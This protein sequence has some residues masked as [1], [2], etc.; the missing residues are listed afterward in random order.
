MS[1][2][3][4]LRSFD[5]YTKPL[6]DFRVRTISG[7]TVT[8]ISAVLI[9]FLF[10]TETINF[11]SVDVVE[12]LYVDST[13]SEQ[14]VDV[15]FDVTF[16]K[17][18]CAF[19]TVDVMDVSGDNQDDIQDEIYKLRIDAYGKNI[20]GDSA[21]KLAVNINASVNEIATTTVECGSCYGAIEGCCNTCNEVKQAYSLRGWTLDVENVEQCRSDSWVQKLNEYKNE[22]CRVY[23]KV[24]VAKVAGNFHIAPGD[25]FRT[26]RSHAHDLHSLNP[27]KFDTSHVINH[28]SFGTPFPGKKYPLNGKH[29]AANKGGIMYQYYLKVVP[30]LYVYLDSNNNVFSHQFSVTTNQKDVALSASGL[31]GF[32]VHYEFSP[33]MIKYEERRQSWSSFL[34]SLCAIIGG[35][36]TVASLIDAFIYNSSRVV[37]TKMEL[38]KAS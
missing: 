36:F 20:S 12:Q 5:A 30:T 18:S 27:Q 8:L 26:H 25:P 11:L 34:V 13:S 22:G 16:K 28:L 33:L 17:L 1:L 37:L 19:V 4:S 24:Q 38:N 6:E 29:F 21:V 35:L 14:R 9:V 15:N 32:F 3:A 31:P 10:L 7:G 23:G 2:L